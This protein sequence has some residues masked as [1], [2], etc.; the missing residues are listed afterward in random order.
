M[1]TARTNKNNRNRLRKQLREAGVPEADIDARL[2]ALRLRQ[3]RSRDVSGVVNTSG[4]HQERRRLFRKRLREAGVPEP[5][6]AQAS[7]RLAARQAAARRAGVPL[8]DMEAIY[9]QTWRELRLDDKGY[10]PNPGDSVLRGAARATGQTA[11]AVTRGK[12]VTKYQHDKA[13]KETA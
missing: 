4:N 12:T 3:Q 5:V 7:Q 13:S 11:K 8:A 9:E 2:E 10:Q 1:G 6:V